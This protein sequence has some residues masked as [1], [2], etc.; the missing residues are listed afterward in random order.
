[1][2]IRPI[3]LLA[4]LLVS[5]LLSGRASAESGAVN[6]HL[7]LGGMFPP[8]GGIGTFGFDFQLK[9]PVAL[10]FTV[11]AGYLATETSGS[12]VAQGTAGVRLR[13]L[14]N[15]EGYLN[16]RARG[17]DA[18][19]N[20]WLAPRLGVAATDGG[21]WATFDAAIGYE[22]SVVRPMQLGVFLRPGVGVGSSFIGY[23]I[24]GLNF[25]FELG[26]A[27]VWDSDGDRLS[28]EREI[29]KWR[30]RAHHPDSDGD[31]LPDGAEVLD[32]GT[33]PLDAD[34][35]RGGAP[36]GWEVANHRNPRDPSDDDR[37]AD[38]VP[39]H[40][41]ACP[42]T[43]PRTEVDERG[44]A[45]LRREMVLDGITFQLNSAEIL[46]SSAATLERAAQTLRDNPGV[47]VEIAGHTDD[48]GKPDYNLRLSEARARSVA[49]W[50][51]AK[52]IDP[53]RLEPRGYGNTQPKAPNDTDANR[54]RNRRIEFRRLN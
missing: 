29:M 8:Y 45:V 37:D 6:L 39:D 22:W 1:M 10:E 34:T 11:G 24:A 44:C 40:R 12:W 7:E 16:E 13:F 49:A 23:V 33:N 18:A 9:P 31:G 32:F 2:R 41:D 50:L 35:D 28:N 19:G 38:R 30:T 17:G 5:I 47:R 4:S 20:L 42:G 48:L 14:D 21:V 36:D 43:P 51:A 26:K 27:K 52:G 46:P 15:R 3:A 25:S 54:A 53:A